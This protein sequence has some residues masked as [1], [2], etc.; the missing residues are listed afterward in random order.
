MTTRSGVQ[1][2]ILYDPA[3][4]HE[5]YG[6]RP[7]ADDRLQGAQ[8][9]PDG[10]HP[11]RPGVGEKTA[12]KLIREFGSLEGGVRRGST[13]SSRT[14]C[15]TSSWST[16]TPCSSASDLSTIVRDL[17]V[18][19]DLDAARLGDYDRETV[20]RLF[21]EYEFRIA[22]RAPAGD[23][24]R[25]GRGDG[26]GAARASPPTDPC[27]RPESPAAAR[28]SGWGTARPTRPAGRGRR[29]PAVTRLR[30]RG[31]LDGHG[32]SRRRGDRSR[33]R[34][35]TRAAGE[36]IGPPERP[37]DARW[38]RRSP[39]IA[40]IEVGRGD[41]IAAL[42]PGWRP[43]RRWASRLVLDD[44]RPRRGDPL[45][46]AVAGVDGRAM[47]VE[48]PS[49]AAA[50]GALLDDVGTPL[51]GHEVK[52]LLV[53]AARRRRRMRDRC[54]SR[55]TRRSPRTSSTPRCAARPSPTSS[56]SGST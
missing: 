1:N 13:R 16:A 29:A 53:A 45:A 4:I 27:R 49:D 20:I 3:K 48:G 10:Q 51:V 32:G 22:H 30:L 11:G 25:V 36:P 56:P 15:A 6:L 43:S 38:Q 21:R 35:G 12:A 26:R 55:S 42:R 19:L 7:D 40:L 37:A 50:L 24:R 8:G 52:Q 39:T 17:P 23:D 9:R 54:P 18:E 33:R 28:P 47:A 46:L 34:P 31:A 14:S 44:P 41:R 5:R 2:T